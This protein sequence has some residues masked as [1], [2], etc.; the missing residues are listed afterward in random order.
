MNEAAATAAPP[1][2]VTSD[3]S[4]TP[5]HAPITWQLIRTVEHDAELKALLA[6]SIAR[7]AAI[8]PDRQTNPVDSLDAYYD[9]ID[10]SIR[11]MPWEISPQRDYISLYDRIDQSMGCFYFAVSQPLEQLV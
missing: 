2:G 5:R 4:A 7:A 8:N 3:I 10:W 9:F 1:R 6:Q 11:A